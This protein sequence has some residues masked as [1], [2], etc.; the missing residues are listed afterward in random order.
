MLLAFGGCGGQTVA[1]APAPARGK[2]AQGIA[3]TVGPDAVSVETVRRIAKAEGVTLLEARRRAIDDALFAAGARE[4]FHG[5]GRVAS[6][7]NAVLAR[8]LLEELKAKAEAQGPITDAEVARLTERHWYEFDR[9]AS[10]RTTHAVVVVKKP[11]DDAPAKALAQRILA[12]VDGVHDPAEFKKRVEALPKGGLDVRVQNLFPVAADGRVVP[13]QRPLPGAKPETY[14]KKFAEA[15]N[16]IKKVGAH[17]PVI[18]TRF[19][20]HVI[21]LDQRL[22]AKRVPLEERRKKL[23]AEAMD[24]R[25]R[26]AE[27]AILKRLRATTPVQ[28]ARALAALTSKVRIQR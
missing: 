26:N 17:S 4:R 3:A 19:G 14:D 20:Y 12:A 16:A 23:T 25:A 28:V 10:A 22:P 18:H 1:S 7:D 13:D 5:T 9:P 24:D 27:N 8:R 11:A 6:V 2:L 15:A 21:L